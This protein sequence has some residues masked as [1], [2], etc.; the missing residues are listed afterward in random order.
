[1]RERKGQDIHI[2]KVRE[3]KGQGI[4]VERVRERKGQDIYKRRGKGMYMT[5]RKSGRKEG[6]GHKKKVKARKR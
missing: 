4:Y 3:R 5:Y 6:R 2:Q 1:M